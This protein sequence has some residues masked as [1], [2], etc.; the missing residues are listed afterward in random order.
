MIKSIITYKQ[1]PLQ[2]YVKQP[3]KNECAIYEGSTMCHPYEEDK[4]LL[5]TNPLT[6]DA[7]FIE[8]KK[9]DLLFA[10][11]RSSITSE[12]GESIKIVKVYMKLG[13]IGIR[14]EPFVITKANIFEE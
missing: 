12:N 11:E 1:L 5:V 9:S 3:G 6:D 14:Y 2:K 10:E 7:T 4:F 8:F 13:G